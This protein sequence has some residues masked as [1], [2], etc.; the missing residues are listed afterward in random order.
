MVN[1]NNFFFG[2]L[3][4][5]LKPPT[6]AIVL[7]RR[8]YIHSVAISQ[9]CAVST[10]ELTASKIEHSDIV[11]SI[12]QKCGGDE[13]LRDAEHEERAGGD[14]PAGGYYVPPYASKMARIFRRL[15]HTCSM[16]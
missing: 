7:S 8:V 4:V 14:H 2:L 11:H 13:R 5:H 6:T 16:K 3:R 9:V 10:A 15:V 1:A 12:L